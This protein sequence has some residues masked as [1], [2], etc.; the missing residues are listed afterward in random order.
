MKK[1][2]AVIRDSNLFPDWPFCATRI[3]V[4]GTKGFVYVG[5]H[6][7]GWQ[8]YDSNG[9]LARSEYGRQADKEHQDNFIDCIRT[10][11]PAN[12]G[13]EQGH[14]SAMLC[15][16]ANISCRVN[17]RKLTWDVA[18]ES[19]VGDSEANNYL[20]RQYRNPWIISEEA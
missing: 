16:M 2:P 8:A 3:D 10:R 5:R 6:G 20:K 13:A 7:G 15:H 4:C 19:F 18:T 14:Y 1:I 12:A 17:N 11:K 9:D